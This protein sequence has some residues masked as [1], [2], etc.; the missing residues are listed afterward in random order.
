MLP[1]KNSKPQPVIM[2]TWSFVA[3]GSETYALTVARNLDRQLF[4]PILCALDQGGALEEEIK[5][6]QIPHYVMHRKPGIQLGLMWRLFRLF[7]RNKVRVV[8]THHFNQL[9]YSFIGAKLCGA[10]LIHTEHSIEAY[11]RPK[12]RMALRLMSYFCHRIVVIGDD[13]A[14]VMREDVG[15]PPQKLQIILAGVDLDSFGQPREQARNELD[16][17][18]DVPVAAIVARLSSEKNHRNLLEAWK[19]VVT[20]IPQ[21]LLVMAGDGPEKESLVEEITRLGLNDNV[22]MLG[23][24]R[25]VARILAASN[26]FVL[27][28][29]REGLPVSVLEAMAASRPVVATD[30]GDLSKVVKEGET[31]FLVPPKDSAAMAKAL[32]TLL[33]EPEQ[34]IRLGNTGREAVESFGIAPM[35]EAHQKLYTARVSGDKS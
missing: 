32:T 14:R 3:G 21:A 8:H 12:L 16:I 28:S 35:V 33:I 34:A 13:G 29:D 17:D 26:L 15:I 18:T 23:V 4:T 7:R 25:D 1:P 30:V 2:L 5:R 31:G 27:S 24:R 10:R 19:Q 11:K 22:R 6:L 9:F 20:H